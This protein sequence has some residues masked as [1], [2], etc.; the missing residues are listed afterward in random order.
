[1]RMLGHNRVYVPVTLTLILS[2]A[3]AG[4][5]TESTGGLPK[6]APKESRVVA[7]LDLARGYLEQRDFARA[8]DPLER[9]LEID[10]QHVEARVLYAVLLQVEGEYELAEEHFRH[11]LSVDP[12]NAQALNNYGTFLYTRGR[13]ADALE[14]LSQLVR[15]T[16]YRARPQAFENLGL[17]QLKSDQREAAAASFQRALDLNDRQARSALELAHIEYDNGDMRRVDQYLKQYRGIARPNAR[18]LCLSL[19][20]AMAQGDEDLIASHGLALKNL[21]PQQAKRCLART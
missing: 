15:D 18:S 1:M 14:P 4:C 5:V 19:K 13:Y 10:G 21:F 6:P 9:A 20:L 8:R 16:T 2:A 17:A 3:L 12:R 7:Q 11:A